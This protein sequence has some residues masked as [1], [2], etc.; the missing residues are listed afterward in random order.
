MTTQALSPVGVSLKSARAIAALHDTERC[1]FIVGTVSLREANTVSVL[2]Y[3]TEANTLLTQAYV[4]KQ[5]VWHIAPS[6]TNAS[7]LATCHNDAAGKGHRASLWRFPREGR[8]DAGA[9]TLDH[10]VEFGAENASVLQV[11][12]PP[13]GARGLAT[14]EEVRVRFHTL[15]SDLQT[16]CIPAGLPR[17]GRRSRDARGDGSAATGAVPR[18]RNRCRLLGPALCWDRRTCRRHV[19]EHRRHAVHDAR[20]CQRSCSCDACKGRSIQSEARAYDC[21]LRVRFAVLAGRRVSP[22]FWLTLALAVMGA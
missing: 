1:R 5:E 17:V 22:N 10:L 3:D 20:P 2:E 19:R 11:L 8:P 16:A 6:P 7:M 13:H 18:H 4:H 9:P 14:V 12:W 21:D 15:F